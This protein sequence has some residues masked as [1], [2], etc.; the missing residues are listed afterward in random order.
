MAEVGW[1]EE[2]GKDNVLRM[3]R[4]RGTLPVTVQLLDP[5]DRASDR[6]Q[7]ALEAHET[8]AARLGLTS[9]GHSPIGV[10]E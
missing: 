3:L 6:K 8:I 9:S 5:L 7:L 2:P 1:W 4:R 10:D